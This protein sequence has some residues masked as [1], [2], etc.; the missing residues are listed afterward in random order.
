MANKN[1][2]LDIL[3]NSLPKSARQFVNLHELTGGDEIIPLPKLLGYDFF[4]IQ[5]EWAEWALGGFRE[6]KRDDNGKLKEPG[7]VKMILGA[8]G[9]GKT[10][11]II[12]YGC[13]KMLKENPNLTFVIST[14]KQNR[15]KE[16]VTTLSQIMP[17][18]GFKGRFLFESIVLERSDGTFS[19][20]PTFKII[21]VGTTLK[22]NHCNVMIV[23]DPLDPA[24]YKSQAWKEKAMKFTQN[25]QDIADLTVIIGQYVNEDDLYVHYEN[26]LPPENIIRCWHGTI[27]EL[28]VEWED[29]KKQGY[30]LRE[31]GLN[32][33]GKFYPDDERRLK[34]ELTDRMPFGTYCFIDLSFVRKSMK[35]AEG[36]YTAVAFAQ[37]DGVPRQVAHGKTAWQ[38]LIVAGYIFPN[39][40]EMRKKIVDLIQKHQ[41]E[42][43]IYDATMDRFEDLVGFLTVES[44]ERCL[45]P[46]TVLPLKH[47][48][49]KKHNKIIK[50]ICWLQNTGSLK[51][52]EKSDKFFLD[53]VEMY[54]PESEHDDAPD[55]VASLIRDL[56]LNHKRRND[57]LL[58]RVA[59][60]SD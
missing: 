60:E 58:T 44:Y 37:F 21:P 55:A 2:A 30:T 51:Y 14:R 9:Y 33:E 47:E 57:V 3:K 26:T 11:S 25:C 32:Y 22:G 6:K 41:C 12:L 38:E 50:N 15:G 17:K 24:D 10:E 59:F 31:W 48:K 43:V 40:E 56:R 18:M 19:K 39:E 35:S 46:K 5:K 28:D 42:H 53:Q 52:W 7:E 13:T 23:D 45:L 8:R 29:K 49:E 4:P 27:P 34:V 16:M 1:L 20:Q 36:D 54:T